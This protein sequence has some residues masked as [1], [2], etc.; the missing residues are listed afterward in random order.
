M[1]T[2]THERLQEIPGMVPALDALP[3]GCKF[4]D[5]CAR[6]EPRCCE[7]EPALVALGATQVRCHFP[8]EAPP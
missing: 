6:V 4:A 5:R 1:P 8:L 7:E 2:G 3:V